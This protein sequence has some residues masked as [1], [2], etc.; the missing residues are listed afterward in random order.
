[1][2]VVKIKTLRIVI[3]FIGILLFITLNGANWFEDIQEK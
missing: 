3:L 2:Q 1:M